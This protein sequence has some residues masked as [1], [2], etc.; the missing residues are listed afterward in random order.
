MYVYIYIYIY[1]YVYI[2]IV[3]LFA[4]ELKTK[5]VWNKK[6]IMKKKDK[7]YVKLKGYDYLIN[8]WIDEKDII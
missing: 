6:V 5:I 7:L 3:S 4:Q 1:M 8:G 2:Y